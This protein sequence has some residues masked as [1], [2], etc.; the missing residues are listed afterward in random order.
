[1]KRNDFLQLYCIFKGLLKKSQNCLVIYETKTYDGMQS[2]FESIKRTQ[3]LEEIFLGIDFMDSE[4]FR[5]LCDA[6]TFNK[7]IRKLHFYGFYSFF[8]S[9]KKTY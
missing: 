8:F 6:I 9:K 1:M 7:S 3:F 4:C 5:L 2:F